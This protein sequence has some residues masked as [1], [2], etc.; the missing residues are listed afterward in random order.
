ML[1]QFL[2]CYQNKNR[3]E[4]WGLLPQLPKTGG[5]EA[6]FPSRRRNEGLGAE[7]PELKNFAFFCKNN[8]ILGLL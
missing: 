7:L 5:Q 6:L 2:V 3:I 1:A 4:K 8:L